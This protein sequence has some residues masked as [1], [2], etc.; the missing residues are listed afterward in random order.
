M[1]DRHDHQEIHLNLI[2]YFI[3]FILNVIPGILPFS[4]IIKIG[5][6]GFLPLHKLWY[7]TVENNLRRYSYAFFAVTE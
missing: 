5:R 6:V 2:K 7:I 1:H 3:K 4:G